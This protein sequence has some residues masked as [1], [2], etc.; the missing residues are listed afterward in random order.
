MTVELFIQHI[1]SWVSQYTALFCLITIVVW[2]AASL[3]MPLRD[4]QRLRDAAVYF[5][6]I[7]I[8]TIMLELRP[9]KTDVL[10]WAPI[11]WF[12]F[13]MLMM[14]ELL[15]LSFLTEALIK[16]IQRFSARFSHN[17]PEQPAVHSSYRTK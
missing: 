3:L 10:F 4:E 8:L 9:A 13:A 6:A 16:M 15:W 5:F 12:S 1:D 14:M 11:T 7:G 17:I 2:G